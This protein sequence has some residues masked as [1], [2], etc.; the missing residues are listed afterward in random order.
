MYLNTG[1]NMKVYLDSL[2][3]LN[4][5]IDYFIL[6]GTKKLLKRKISIKRLILGSIIGSLTT[7]TIFLKLTSL[8]LLVIKLVLSIFIILVTFGKKNF[9]E[10]IFYFYIIS[11]IIGG[12]LY[13][14]NIRLNYFSLLLVIPIIIN[15]Y[16]KKTKE[17]KLNIKNN[18]IVEI[19]IKDKVYK[20]EGMI[21]TGNRLE[22]PYKKRGVIL[23]NINIDYKKYKYLYVPYHALNYN[24]LIPCIKPDKIIIDNK[25]IT[26]Y[27]I[28]ISKDKF[29]LNGS[30]C[31][32]PNKIQ[33]D[34]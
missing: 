26:N 32:L 8:K 12:L 23:A 6:Y 25:V 30:E 21:D 4:L 7:F 11:I 28:G 17:Y 22:D 29:N 10:N 13:L 15:I 14:I 9:I 2:L 31:I 18:Y 33:E 27:L 3:I 34:L 24:G 20:L 5:F 16:I 1:D 19:I